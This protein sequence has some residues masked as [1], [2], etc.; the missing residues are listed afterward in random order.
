MTYSVPMSFWNT[1]LAAALRALLLLV[2]ALLPS[3]LSYA[4]EDGAEGKKELEA[5]RDRLKHFE[6]VLPRP[7][8]SPGHVDSLMM[9][10]A[11]VQSVGRSLE[12]MRAPQAEVVDYWAGRMRDKKFADRTVELLKVNRV[13]ALA[14]G[15]LAAAAKTYRM[16]AKDA[17]IVKHHTGLTPAQK[18]KLLRQAGIPDRLRKTKSA[19]NVI[20]EK[21]GYLDPHANTDWAPI[22][23]LLRTDLTKVAQGIA[24]IREGELQT[25]LALRHTYWKSIAKPAALEKAGGELDQLR[26]AREGTFLSFVAAGLNPSLPVEFIENDVLLGEYMDAVT[27]YDRKLIEATNLEGVGNN[28]RLQ[29]V[30]DSLFEIRPSVR[31][32]VLLLEKGRRLFADRLLT[33]IAE[34][35]ISAAAYQRGDKKLVYQELRFASLATRLNPTNNRASQ[36]VSDC[37]A[38]LREL[39]PETLSAAE[40]IRLGFS[41]ALAGDYGKAA[42][43]LAQGHRA[44]PA[45]KGLTEWHMVVSYVTSGLASAATIWEGSHPEAQQ[46]PW[47]HA[48]AQAKLVEIVYGGLWLLA[49]RA[50]RESMLYAAFKHYSLAYAAVA[51]LKGSSYSAWVKDERKV[52]RN[53]LSELYMKLPLKPTLPPLPARSAAEAQRCV[54]N[55]QWHQAE[56]NYS[57]ALEQAPW[58]PEGHYNLALVTGALYWPSP[59]AVREMELYLALAPNG[60]SRNTAAEKLEA[61][62]TAIRDAVRRGARVRGDL[63]FLI[64]PSVEGW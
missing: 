3:R 54:E 1:H 43:A 49:E 63:P 40:F 4:G 31:R 22:Y 23:K 56:T 53:R 64:T 47:S 14:A 52:L 50:R 39:D 8:N 20:L 36:I 16:M 26:A 21:M 25:L 48:E 37:Y 30:L 51:E 62:K 27:A 35:C 42:N 6:S 38:A 41:Q 17:E 44:Y 19:L 13:F 55:G 11:L 12:W 7:N 32:R 45:D 58:W 33:D 60:D 34:K 10:E 46:R 57:Q 59:R 5:L 29:K 9:G 28:V 15:K 24:K 2:L 18:E 61:W